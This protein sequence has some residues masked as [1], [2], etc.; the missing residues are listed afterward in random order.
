MI[1]DEFPSLDE[2]SEEFS[3]PSNKFYVLTPQLHHLLRSMVF[4]F[5]Q[6]EVLHCSV[7]QKSTDALP[8][9]GIAHFS[10]VLNRNYP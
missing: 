6:A 8:N 1:R 3:E 9:R 4:V 2:L 5:D 10:Y 7:F